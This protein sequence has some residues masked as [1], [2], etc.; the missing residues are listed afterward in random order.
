M[1]GLHRGGHQIYSFSQAAAN[2]WLVFH[3]LRTVLYL[4]M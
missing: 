1:H 4:D 2:A 3:L